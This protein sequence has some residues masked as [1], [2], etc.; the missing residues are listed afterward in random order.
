MKAISTFPLR[1][2]RSIK[3]AVVKVSKQDGTSINQFI[4]TAVAEK[5]AVMDA[6]LFFKARQ[7]RAD[8]KKF[9]AIMKRRRGQPPRAGDEA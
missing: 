4:A 9:D 1:L 5:L 6:E 8:L 3:A 2:P 7:G